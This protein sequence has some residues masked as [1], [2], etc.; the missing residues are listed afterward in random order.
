MG[1]YAK[2]NLPIFL[3]LIFFLFIQAQSRPLLPGERLEYEARFGMIRLGRMVIEIVDTITMEGVLCYRISSRINSNPDLH[4]LFSLNDTVNV[5]TSVNE[6]LPLVYEKRIHE[7]KYSNYY[8]Y[9]F[10]QESLFVIV[11][12]S[13]KVKI[14]NPVMDLLSFWYY[15]RKLRLIEHDTIH[16]IL[17]ESMKEHRVDCLIGKKEVVKTPMGRFLAI[18]VTP[19]TQGKGVF[20]PTGSMDIWYSDDENRLPVQIITK[21]KFGTVVFKLMG[22]KY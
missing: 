10:S 7:G 9:N 2:E 8:K 4:F 14:K 19:K 17:F 20:G 15:L 16:L 22:V 1:F 5:I 11:N 3:F 13:T 18:R 21:L 6:L 12:D